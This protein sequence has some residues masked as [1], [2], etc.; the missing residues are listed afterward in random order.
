MI[1]ELFSMLDAASE[2]S[3]NYELRK[4]DFTEINEKISVST[5]YTPDMGYET[6]VLLDGHAH[7]VE[8]YGECRSASVIGHNKW[9]KQI[10]GMT[11]INNL[12]YGEIVSGS[13]ISLV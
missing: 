5:V 11:E 8:R 12:G 13:V 2:M 4:V 10:P 7:P 3:E 9:V 6:A 1:S